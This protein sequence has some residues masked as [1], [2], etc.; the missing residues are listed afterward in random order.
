MAM[1]ELTDPKKVKGK[2][3][4]SLTSKTASLRA[5]TTDLKMR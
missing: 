5:T 3:A 2:K 4:Q 1:N